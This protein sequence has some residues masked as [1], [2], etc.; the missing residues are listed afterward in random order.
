MEEG[1]ILDLEHVMSAKRREEYFDGVSY[2]PLV[3]LTIRIQFFRETLG[4]IASEGIWFGCC[5]P[6]LLVGSRVM[7]VR[8]DA[9]AKK[10]WLPVSPAQRMDHQPFSRIESE[11][12]VN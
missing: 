1:G 2:T 7:E 11:D 8:M 9:A 3:Q 6:R 4:E 10:G 12:S 5:G